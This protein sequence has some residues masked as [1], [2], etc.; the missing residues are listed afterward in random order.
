VEAAGT[1]ARQDLSIRAI[2]RSWPAPRIGAAAADMLSSRT[3]GSAGVGLAPCRDH[4][5]DRHV[6]T[7]ST[8]AVWTPVDRSGR[9]V[10]RRSR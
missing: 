5:H 1:G 6:A 8:I 7:T 3:A 4:V 2:D 10:D 9:I